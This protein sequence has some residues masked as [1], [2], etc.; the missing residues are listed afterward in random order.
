MP[1]E[2]SDKRLSP[3][4]LKRHL[5]VFGQQSAQLSQSTGD[6][7]EYRLV[8]VR[9]HFLFEMRNAQCIHAPYFAL[10]RRHRPGDDSQQSRLAGAVPTH[11]ADPLTGIDLKVDTCEQRN[12]PVGKGN[13]FK[14]KQRHGW[15]LT[16]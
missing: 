12:I 3:C 15:R 9:R 4:K 10:V 11:Q 13:I 2:Q 14:T 8:G 1:P 7:L 6:D 5:V 16:N